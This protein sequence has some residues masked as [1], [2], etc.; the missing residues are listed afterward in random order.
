MAMASPQYLTKKPTAAG[1]EDTNPNDEQG[2]YANGL[3]NL[4]SA[5]YSAAGAAENAAKGVGDG[6]LKE[7]SVWSKDTGNAGYPD[8]TQQTASASNPVMPSSGNT[9]VNRGQTQQTPQIG[10]AHV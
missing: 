5:T 10:R 8:P 3:P 7:G 1:D 9:G 6:P 2:E 4:T